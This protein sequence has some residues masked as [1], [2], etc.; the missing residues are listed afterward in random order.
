MNI[1]HATLD[2][3]REWFKTMPNRTTA[4]E[5]AVAA[6]DAEEAGAITKEAALS[7]MARTK[8]YRSQ[9]DGWLDGEAA[10]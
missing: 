6:L 10:S 5:Y 9:A 7:I 8:R 4:D 2:D 1:R 3:A